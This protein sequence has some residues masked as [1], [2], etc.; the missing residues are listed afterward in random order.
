MVEKA[1]KMS[2]QKEKTLRF[3]F[4]DIFDTKAEEEFY[5]RLAQEVLRQSASKI[6]G[7][8][9]NAKKFMGRFVPRLSFSPEPN[10]DFSLGLDWK[11][12]KKQPGDILDLA[13]NIA[14][15]NKIYSVHRR[16]PEHWKFQ[17]SG[18]FPKKVEIQ[19][20]K[21]PKHGILPVWQ[22]K[23]HAYGCVHIPINAVL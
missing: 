8:M 14:K 6:E 15:E 4:I 16:I 3:C 18:C 17:G 13:E 10:S 22:Q 12:V 7:W 1:A 9:E 19:L 20:A 5:Q 21:T 11:E 2:M 23:A